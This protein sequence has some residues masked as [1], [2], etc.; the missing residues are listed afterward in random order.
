MFS[1]QETDSML[2]FLQSSCKRL[3]GYFSNWHRYVSTSSEY[4][5]QTAITQEFT[6]L[7]KRTREFCGKELFDE[8]IERIQAEC[9]AKEKG[10][11]TLCLKKP[12]IEDNLCRECNERNNKFVD[13]VE[14]EFKRREFID[15]DAGKQKH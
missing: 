13:G 6:L 15:M 10:L 8:K 4:T 12:S 5:V 7:Y 1:I 14:K 9:E 3:F 2:V 11:C